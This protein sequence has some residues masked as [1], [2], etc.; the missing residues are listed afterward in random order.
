MNPREI[1]KKDWEIRQEFLKSKSMSQEEKELILEILQT[2]NETLSI[3]SKTLKE[4]IEI[5]EKAREKTHKECP[6]LFN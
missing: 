2:K 3:I 4:C 5:I 6:N 1:G